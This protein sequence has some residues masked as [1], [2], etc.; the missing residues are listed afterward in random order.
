MA[1][2]ALTADRREELA[3][4]LGDEQRLR[5]EYPKVAE[6]LDT[7]P[8]LP[9]TGNDQ[10]DAAFDLRLAHY[11]TGGPSISAN[12][13]WDIV[14]PSVSEYQGRRVVD[15][16]RP[17]GSAR[18]GFAQTTCRPPMPTRFRRRRPWCG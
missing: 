3:G 7:A 11:M 16:G 14:A 13:Y 15:G 4:L 9:G 10:A 17:R 6:Y 1:E 12:P 8:M 2:L 18:L 5:T